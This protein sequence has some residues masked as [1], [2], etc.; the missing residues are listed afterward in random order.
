M[1]YRKTISI[2]CALAIMIP[3]SALVNPLYAK[4]EGVFSM[5]N[6]VFGGRIVN[7]YL[8]ATNTSFEVSAYLPDFVN[9][10]HTELLLDGDSFAQVITGTQTTEGSY[11][12]LSG[13]ST[14][15]ELQT[16]ISPGGHIL[17]IRKTLSLGVTENEGGLPLIADYS[18]PGG[19][20]SSTYLDDGYLK[21]GDKID[22]M[23]ELSGQDLTKDIADISAT[24]NGKNLSWS[25]AIPNKYRSIYKVSE[26]DKD[27]PNPIQIGNLIIADK[28][29]NKS[30]PIA[31]FDITI[32]IDANSPKIN[33]VSPVNNKMYASETTQLQYSSSDPVVSV[34]I[35]SKSINPASAKL[36]PL[37]DGK[38]IL[39][40]TAQDKAQNKT[41]QI[42]SF[43]IDTIAP[44]FSIIIQP[45]GGT[46]TQKDK[47]VFSGTSEPGAQVQLEVYSDAQTAATVVDASGNWRIEFDSSNL[48]AGDHKAYLTFTDSAGNYIKSDQMAFRVMS[49]TP[50][51]ASGTKIALAQAK[52]T[53][54]DVSATTLCDDGSGTCPVQESDKT[55]VASNNIISSESQ[56]STGVN[57][58]AWIILL[59]IIV[60]ASALA[61]AGYYGYGW[62]IASS[63][64]S[65]GSTVLGD[66]PEDEES[67]KDEIVNFADTKQ[68]AAKI[69]PAEPPRDDFDEGPPKTR[70]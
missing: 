59:A 30:A 37:K 63:S 57:W 32:P 14:P 54:S 35:D 50:T 24:Y 69:E 9:I 3:I 13:T 1:N 51:V 25:P 26:G 58:S 18:A 5:N 41:A 23:L 17:S 4:A 38:H 2:I 28:A 64:S 52:A 67:E 11:R 55:E 22:F 61:T 44:G 21:V 16:Q 46:V 47:I 48:E 19:S 40:I 6:T 56:R 33:I 15:T 49:P 12:F 10:S 31:T 8:N 29:G 43:S 20:I 70:W 36:G 60:L 65:R 45:D 42:V 62:A 27:R 7:G 34:K 66:E 53:R 39:E 68:E